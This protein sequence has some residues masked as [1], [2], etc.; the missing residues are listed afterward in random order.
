MT[1]NSK[2]LASNKILKMEFKS[3]GKK[4]EKKYCMYFETIN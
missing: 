2:Q 4:K 1:H 3:T